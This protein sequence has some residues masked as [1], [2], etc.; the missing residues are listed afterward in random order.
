MLLVRRTTDL[1]LVAG[2]LTSYVNLCW[3]IGQFIASG[4]LVGVES[5][6]DSWG[7]KIPYA[8]QWVWPLPIIAV[9]V[10]CPESPTWLVKHNKLDEARKAVSRLQS[11]KASGV[12]PNPYETVALLVKTDAIEQEISGGSSYLE[13]FKGVNLRRT[14]IATVT[15]TI[16]QMC[17]PVLQTYATYL[18]VSA[19]LAETEAFNMTLGLYAI[20]FAGTVLSWPLIHR[21]GRRSIF[22]SGLIGIFVSLMIVGFLGIPGSNSASWAA[23]A[24]LLST[25]LLSA[26]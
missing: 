16:Q 25:T 23:G 24:F 13:C 7:W 9:C 10:L 4:V 15:W 20:A 14:E 5:R 3:V 17:G 18:F 8:I 26:R 11:S 2:Y 21:F 12:I 6:V 1:M 19:G 22:L